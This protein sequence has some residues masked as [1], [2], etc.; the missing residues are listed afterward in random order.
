MHFW[1]HLL[2]AVCLFGSCGSLR[3]LCGP[4]RR[5]L[6]MLRGQNAG[7]RRGGLA[8]QSCPPRSSSLYSQDVQAIGQQPQ[9]L[10]LHARYGKR[11]CLQQQ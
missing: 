6:P 11:R 9:L 2:L 8:L 10:A 5:E 1:G 3:A 7:S 4:H